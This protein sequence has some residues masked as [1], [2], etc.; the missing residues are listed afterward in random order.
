[1]DEILCRAF[2]ARV[3]RSEPGVLRAR[4][5]PYGVRIEVVD[6]AGSYAEEFARGAFARQIETA[7][8]DLGVMRRVQLRDEHERGSGKIGWAS[9]LEDRSDALYGEFAILP[10]RQADV[11][12]LLEGGISDVSIGFA[13]L[14][15]RS[16]GGVKIRTRV[17]LDHVALEPA[18]AYP[19]AEVLALRADMP[20]AETEA[21]AEA[22]DH[23]ERLTEAQRW[24]QEA[25]ARQAQ[26]EAARVR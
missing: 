25:T 16:A 6:P 18:G 10:S 12:A 17:R 13:P 21:E 7:R 4:L 26:W 8:R 14:A 3:E 20:D 11:E 5:V 23:E 22:A 2:G 24:L 19:G 1:M 15:T 9:S